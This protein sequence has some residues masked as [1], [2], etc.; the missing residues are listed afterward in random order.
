MVQGRR[1]YLF[2]SLISKGVI[3]VAMGAGDTGRF[4]TGEH[5][6]GALLCV[7]LPAVGSVVGGVSTVLCSCGCGVVGCGAICTEMAGFGAV[8]ALCGSGVVGRDGCE[9]ESSCV[10]GGDVTATGRF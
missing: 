2:T 8:E 1:S 9:R 3:G 10:L 5:V 7:G 6:I 4:A